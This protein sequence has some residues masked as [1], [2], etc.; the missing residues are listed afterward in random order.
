MVSDRRAT[1][2]ER[3][4]KLG[5]C[6]SVCKLYAERKS[7]LKKTSDVFAVAIVEKNDS[8]ELAECSR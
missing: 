2:E 4:T 3:E 5:L 7:D 1:V 6:P 8:Q